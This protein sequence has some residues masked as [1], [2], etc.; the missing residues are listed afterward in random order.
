MIF[1][2][3]YLKSYIRVIRYSIGSNVIKELCVCV[4][5]EERPYQL[6]RLQRKT[7][8]AQRTSY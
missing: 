2:Y 4:W 6:N 1:K 8:E 7:E 5:T 3:Y